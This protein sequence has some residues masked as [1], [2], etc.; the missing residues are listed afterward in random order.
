MTRTLQLC[1]ISSLF[2]ASG[3]SDLQPRLPEGTLKA[4]IPLKSVTTWRETEPVA[5]SDDA[6]DDPAIWIHPQDASASLVIGTN[7]QRGLV[8][9]DLQG[10]LVQELETGLPNNV[11]LRQNVSLNGSLVDVAI[12]SNRAAN[13]LDVYQLDRGNGW[14]SLVGRQA[15]QLPEPYGACMYR[16][17]DGS[18]YAFVNDKNGRF[19]QWQIE[20]LRPLRLSLRREFSLASQPEGCAADDATGV[21]FAG[22]EALGVWKLGAAPDWKGQ[23]EL[24]YS[25]EDGIFTADVEGMDIWRRGDQAVLVV[26]SQGD[27][28]YALF[29][30]NPPHTYLGSFQLV[31]SESGPDGVEETDGLAVTS[32]NLGPG[33]ESGLLVV[34]DG[35]NL[36]PAE[37]Q[38]F[39]LVPWNRVEAVLPADWLFR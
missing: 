32:V 29:D 3:C 12:A 1:L 26:S 38:N 36:E 20:S 13:T 27:Y 4:G 23:P 15:L 6:A 21:L 37:N 35:F 17:P 9:Y 22:E 10:R 25:M 33:L 11:D 28:S 5:T 14:I 34:Q 19:Q 24:L 2:M 7:K 16:S 39:K 30:A 31:G 8:V 18:V